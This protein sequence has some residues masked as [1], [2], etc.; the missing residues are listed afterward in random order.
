MKPG[1]PVVIFAEGIFAL[2]IAFFLTVVFV[3]L[4]RRARSWRQILVF[5]VLVF[6]AAW[7]GGIWI[8]PVGPAILGVYWLSFFAVGL[9]FALLQEALAASARRAAP[10]EPMRETEAKEERELESIFN[11][12]LL[13]LLALFIIAII[14]GYAHR[15][16]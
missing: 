6:L 4:G 16:A 11:I 9:V 12:F 7:A 3:V 8:G 14:L 1:V 5:S 10:R 15:P 2:G 13:V